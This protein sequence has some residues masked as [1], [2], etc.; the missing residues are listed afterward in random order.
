MKKEIALK[1]LQNHLPNLQSKYPI[2]QLGIFGSVTRGENGPESDLD[3]L[4]H[5]NGPIGFEIV[6]LAHE[7]EGL[8]NCPVDLVS[9]KGIKPHYWEQIQ[10]EVI[11]A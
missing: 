2:D 6:D 1:I 3:V 9:Q 10:P 8:L 7:L 4:V 5:F 11:Y